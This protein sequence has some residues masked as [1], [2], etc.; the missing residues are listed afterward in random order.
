MGKF[1]AAATFIMV[2]A[3]SY[4]AYEIDIRKTS[5]HSP[6][7]FDGE[8]LTVTVENGAT[9]KDVTNRLFLTLIHI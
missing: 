1:F 5:L 8:T 4:A 3:T 6:L 7:I 2:V 9:L